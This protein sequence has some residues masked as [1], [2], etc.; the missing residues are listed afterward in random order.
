MVSVGVN[1]ASN[2]SPLQKVTIKYIFDSVRNPRPEIAAKIRQLRIIRELDNKQYGLLK[3]ELPYFVCAM[4][5]PPY[6]RKENF[7]YT[8]YFVID[9][10][11]ITSKQLSLNELRSR[12]EKDSRVVLAFLSPGEDGLK[13]LFKFKERC[14][15]AGLYSLFYKVF[16]SHFSQQY[17]LSQV[18]DFQ[19]CD[20]SRACFISMDSDA[21]YN[22]DAE[23]VDMQQ[24]LPMND[25]QRLFDLKHEQEKRLNAL[26][27]S[28][29][30]VETNVDPDKEAM[31]RI[32]GLL[33]P[34]K[35]KEQK[36]V[37]VPQVLNDIMDDLKKYVEQ[38]G[39]VVTEI[40]NI[41]YGKKLRFSLGLKQAEL[42]L[43]YGKKGF[44]VVCSPRTGTNEE[45]NSLMVDVVT[46][47][48]NSQ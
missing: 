38:T 41:Q 34:Q 40:I 37:F 44:S 33:N 25:T 2:A 15:D 3:K 43:F 11:H 45:L 12:I 18:I 20:V 21:Y 39:V 16:A 24:Y 14:Y 27:S 17:G 4:F 9:I 26:K 19:T 1:V 29:E 42:N 28:A 30:K 8:E 46:N 13:V 32:R 23:T 31:T 48:I 10:D 35:K 22:P 7:A 47:F 36:P 5:N 6:R